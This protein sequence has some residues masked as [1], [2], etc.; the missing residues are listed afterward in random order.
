MDGRRWRRY[1][2]N[3]PWSVIQTQVVECLLLQEIILLSYLFRDIH[4]EE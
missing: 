4:G 1:V 3:D 2:S